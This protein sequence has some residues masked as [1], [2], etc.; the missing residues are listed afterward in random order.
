M[1]Q[2]LC[3]APLPLTRSCAAVRILSPHPGARVRSGRVVSVVVRVGQQVGGREA[4][5]EELDGED[6]PRGW[7]LVLL[8]D[9]Q[10]PQT[11][12]RKV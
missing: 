11:V 2:R 3:S 8:Q 10:P 1:I 9:G 6:L 4:L 5:R 7:V 12:G